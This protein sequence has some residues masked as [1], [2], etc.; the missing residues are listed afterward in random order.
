METQ[1]IL[2]RSL[3]VVFIASVIWTITVS[4]DTEKNTAEKFSICCTAVST[5]ELTDPII[6]FRLQKQSLP[7]LMAVIFKTERGEFCYDPRQPWVKEKVKLLAKN[8]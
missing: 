6:G 7:C 3:A 4:A 2:M 5:V 8:A 1:R